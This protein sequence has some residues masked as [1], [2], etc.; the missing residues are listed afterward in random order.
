MSKNPPVKISDLSS[1]HMMAMEAMKSQLLIVLVNRLG[2]A[3]EI[4]VH[5]IDGTGKF[6]MTMRLDPDTR[7]FFFEVIDK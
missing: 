5:E 2:G 1:D 3:V 4:P 6:N 7:T